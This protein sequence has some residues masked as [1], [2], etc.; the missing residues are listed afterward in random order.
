[1]KWI[2]CTERLPEENQMVR[3]RFKA[4][5]NKFV[6]GNYRAND[7]SIVETDFEFSKYAPTYRGLYNEELIEWMPIEVGDN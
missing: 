2:K 4:Y 3:G 6:A 5:N 7:Y 1:M